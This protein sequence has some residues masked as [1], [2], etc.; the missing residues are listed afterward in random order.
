MQRD[1]TE[2]AELC[3]M[4]QQAWRDMDAHYAQY[5]LAKERLFKTD[6]WNRL[7]PKEQSRVLE[8][9]RKADQAILDLIASTRPN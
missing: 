5:Q 8:L 4:I 7:S 3:N 6:D 9:L 1:E 2:I